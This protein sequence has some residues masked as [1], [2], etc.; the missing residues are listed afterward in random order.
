MIA[1]VA[2][3]LAFVEPLR[4]A[5]EVL[6]VLPT[7]AY[8]GSLAIVELIA[9]GLIAAFS[10]AAGFALWNGSP[11]GRRLARLAVFAVT[12]RAIQSLTWSVMPNDTPPGSE[13]LSA[14]VAI[15]VSAIALLVLRRTSRPTRPRPT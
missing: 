11:D 13:L 4:F 7:I 2:A 5:T 10:A 6:A 8:R 14:G 1:I 3:L 12:A 15:S 9:H